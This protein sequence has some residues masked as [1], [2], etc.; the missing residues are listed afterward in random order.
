M[1]FGI[2]FGKQKSSGS[3]TTDVSKVESGTQTESG[4]KT[5]TGTTTTSGATQT[6]QSGSTTQQGTTAQ[7]S[8]GTESK[9]GTTTQFSSGVL[10]GLESAVASLLGA[11]PTGTQQYESD[12][13]K[14][15]FIQAGMDAAS[16]RITGDTELAL[17]S[18]F[19]QFGGRDDSN[20]MAALLATRA[21][22]DAAAAL[23][24]A[25]A[26]LESQ[27][28]GIGRENFG[29]NLQGLGLNQQ[30]L[31]GILGALKGGVSTSAEQV[32]TAENVTGQTSQ[33]GTSQQV[34]SE[35]TQQTQVQQ[36][37][38]ILNSIVSGTTTTVGTESTKQKGKV[39]GGGVGLS[40]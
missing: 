14:D 15:A 18:M 9:T 1:A 30:F 20:S 31:Q 27:A 24:G 36:L 21:R 7:Q 8:T 33:V 25:R 10:G 28:E 5:S 29:A 6:S 26:N 19:D 22:G 13:N 38:E 32:A 4:T 2:S 11:I 16:S 37:A 17:N 39:A 40:I 35:T 23:A 12:F 34:G 3:S